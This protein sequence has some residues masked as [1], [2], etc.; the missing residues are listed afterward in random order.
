MVYIFSGGF[1]AMKSLTGFFVTVVF[2]V[3][4]AAQTPGAQS[5]DAKSK[6]AEKAPAAPRTAEPQSKM[7]QPQAKPAD[8]AP[9]KPKQDAVAGLPKPAPEIE[10]VLKMLQGRWQTEEKHEPSAM[11]PNGGVGK[12]QEGIRPGPGRLSLIGE[13]TSQGPMGEFSG[14]GIMLWDS[15][16]RAYHLHWTD[17]T[18]PAMTVT[19][20]RWQ[21]DDLIFTG[22]EMQG[23][24]RVYTRHG[25]TELKPDSF[26][27]TLDVG[28]SATQL[29]RSMTVKYTKVNMQQMMQDRLERLRGPQKQ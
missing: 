4:L 12:G 21:G 17:N 7:A 24:K 22:S 29:K 10:R 25:F 23:D 13:Y 26:T 28:P 11:L 19:T 15:S 9:P 18:S 8:K 5:P 16:E 6:P 2:A 27:Y 14:I 20:G 3:A 1:H